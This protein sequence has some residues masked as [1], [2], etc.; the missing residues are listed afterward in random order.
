M[1]KRKAKKRT[2][3][4]KSKYLSTSSDWSFELI[5]KYYYEIERIATKKFGLEVYANE[6]DVI[7]SEQML[8]AYSSNAMP[9][10]YNHWS[11]GKHFVQ[12]ETYYLHKGMGL[13][14]EVVI[15]SNPC[16]AYLMEENT[17]V[18]QALVM[19]HACFGHNSFF[20]NNYM[21]TQWTDADAII[22]Y[23]V[24]AKKYIA[25]CEEKY[26]VEE[27]EEVLDSCHTI[28]NYGVDRYKRAPEL[29][30]VEEEERQK[31]RDE[32]RQKNLNDLWRTIPK[33]EKEDKLEE[34]EL[35]PSEPQE[36]VLYFIEKNAPNLETWKRE[37]I[38]IVRKINQYFYPQRQTKLMNE[39]WATFWHYTIINELYNEGKVNDAFMLEFISHHTNVIMQYPF[40]SKYYGGV[41]VYALGFAMFMDIKRM[42]E[43]PTDEDKEWFPDLA[44]KDWNETVHFAMLNFKDES[45]IQQFLSPKV[46]RDFHFF[47]VIDD[48]EDTE[49]EVSA[50]HDKS[51]YR[52]VRSILSKQYD[53]I[54]IEP[55][56]Q[57]YSVDRWGDR[58]L[59]LRHYMHNRRPLDAES[60]EDVL[61]HVMNLW[62]FDVALQSVDENDEVKAEW[63][64]AEGGSL[65][66]VFGD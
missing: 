48:D 59:T 58:K 27:V 29:S 61:K 54:A 64:M 20:K 42:C 23:L 18:L 17:M 30:I 56:I 14:Y 11:Y 25:E 1:A 53:T 57:V 16:I 60:T 22:D 46:I 37:L 62:K 4:R 32:F 44:G 45:F 3:K 40:N 49:L 2:Y 63:Q 35:F 39:G 5:E 47:S 8:D 24:F 43:N 6:I 21:F 38:R 19:A 33:K 10:M 55:N 12:Q 34:E 51:G 52:Q 36:N 7:S 41:N 65:I 31:E 15:N 28:Q 13:A 26:G 50:I 66:D 9:V